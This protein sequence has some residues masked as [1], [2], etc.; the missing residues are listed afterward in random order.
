[1]DTEQVWSRRK[2][3]EQSQDATQE[4]T[5]PVQIVNAPV[6][7]SSYEP[8]RRMNANAVAVPKRFYRTFW[9]GIAIRALSYHRAKDDRVC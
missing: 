8:M 7:P 2:S 6:N 9:R 1:M 3:T 5:P 4:Q